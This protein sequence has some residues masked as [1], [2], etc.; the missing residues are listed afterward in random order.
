MKAANGKAIAYRPDLPDEQGRQR[1][2]LDVYAPDAPGDTR[3]VVVWFYG[4]GMTTGDRQ[5]PG[6]F[7]GRDLV[8]V[9]P[10]YR[11]SPS[12]KAPAYIEDAAAA[13]AW[14]F[15]HIASFGG[16]DRRIF[17]AGGSAGAYLA[18]MITMDPR[19][20]AVHEVDAGRLAGLISMT[21]Q[22]ITH[23]T[24]RAERG[25]PE[26]RPVIDELA[27]LFH[28][29]ADAPPVL[30]VTGDR[31]LELPGRYEENAYFAAMMKSVGHRDIT[32]HEMKGADHGAVEE[33]GRLLLLDFVG[34]LAG[35]P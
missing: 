24:I 4:G 34:R 28:V 27:P 16:D 12:V 20:L 1:C 14:T 22:M 29:R 31:E 8:V 10:D 3:P 25:I 6:M 21:G 7:S 13:V 11:L 18:T 30:L 17:V 9:T 35:R 26:S 23:F 33:A 19:W 2:L 15:K 32:L 5:W